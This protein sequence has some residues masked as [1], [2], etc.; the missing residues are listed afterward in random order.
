MSDWTQITDPVAWARAL[1][2]FPAPHTLQSWA[3]GDFKSRWGWSA[4]HWAHPTAALQILR[5]RAGP[6]AVLYAPKGPV[7]RDLAGY[8]AALSQLESQARSSRALWV[9]IDGDPAPEGV[10]AAWTPESLE[11]TRALLRVRGWRPAN[12][13]IQFRNTMLTDVRATDEALLARM[14]SKCRYNVR[15]AERRGV[16]I[17]LVQPVTGADAALIYAMYAETG[18]R[19]GFFVRDAEYYLDAWRSMDAVALIAEHN[20][21]AL[22]SLVLFKT[23]A[24][25]WYFYGMSRS[26]GREHMPNH[27]LQWHALRWARD[28][29]CAVY[30]WWG[31]PEALVETD[32]M[33]GVYRFKESFGAQFVEGVGAWDFAPSALLYKTYG[34]VIPRFLEIMRR[35]RG[36]AAASTAAGA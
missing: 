19:D 17:R 34:Q 29:G 30:D 1:E 35:R 21:E 6:F 22:G 14:G 32:S 5:R 8:T 4:T 2:Q 27:L 13:Q 15:L 36:V 7:T 28:S 12:D 25:A 3:W 9:K 20:G 16:T 23:G 24:R 31:A 10:G 33:W 11:Q 26:I 18:T